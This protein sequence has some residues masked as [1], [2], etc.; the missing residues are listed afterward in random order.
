MKSL[1]TILLLIVSNVF[2]TF[3][4]YGHLKLQEMKVTTS[5]P[6]IGIILLSWG[7][8]FFEYCFQ[9]PANRIGFQ[10]NGGPFSLVQLKVIQECITLI[11]FGIF[12]TVLFRGESLHWNHFAAF[13]CL[14]LA[15]YFVFMK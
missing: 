5:W 10:D 3:A 8:A 4:W 6:L 2:M 7:I 9:V 12:T 14:V 11:I 13:V 15:V 1:I